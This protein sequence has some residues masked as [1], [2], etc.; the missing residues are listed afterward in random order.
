MK[1]Y[2]QLHRL[3]APLVVA[4]P[5]AI[6]GCGSSSNT[7]EPMV[8]PPPP[9]PAGPTDLEQTQAD[10]AAAAAAAMAA[11]AD[12]AASAAS[13]AMA[14]ANIATHQT[15]GMAADNNMQAQMAAAAAMAAYEAAKAA[16]A[17]AATAADSP[18]AEDARS[19]AL[20]AQ[21]TAEAEAMKAAEAAMK[22][23]EAAMMELKIVGTMK[24]VGESSIDATMGALT[25]TVGEGAAAKTVLTGLR[26]EKTTEGSAVAGRS[27]HPVTAAA[28][29]VATLAVDESKGRAY[30]QMVEA[31]TLKIGKELDTTDDAARLVLFDKYA[32]EN[33]VGVYLKRTLA[34]TEDAADG[35]DVAAGNLFIRTKSD[36]SKI[37]NV[38]AAGNIV[39]PPTDEAGKAS[40]PKAPTLTTIGT[41]IEA[42][43]DA[44]PAAATAPETDAILGITTDTSGTGN[45]DYEDEVKKEAKPKTVSSVKDGDDTRYVVVETTTTNADG[46]VDTEY[47]YVDITALAAAS[48]L[49]AM[50]PIQTRVRANV[51]AAI[52]YKHIHFGA[53][54][55]LSAAKASGAQTIADLGIGFVQSIGTG[56]TGSDM[57]NSGNASYT[58]NWAGMVQ[59]ANAEG[60]GAITLN[61]GAASLAA[62]FA[63]GEIAAT[64]SGLATLEGAITGNTFAGSKATVVSSD[65]Y[66]LQSTAKFTGTFGGG[67]YG[68]G[69]AEAGGIFDFGTT[70]NTG[71]AFRGAF[72]GAKDE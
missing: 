6:A 15:N 41:F 58:G 68:S 60:K 44:T 64:L 10:A 9:P 40:L 22:A 70:D 26:S 14:A 45:L 30:R 2:L 31:R 25:T 51:P 47:R 42:E 16:A 17:S 18:A 71:G 4:V 69:A 24:S 33:P 27:F 48:P 3:M 63:D 57:P 72:G 34:Q 38:D 23:A 21:A 66:G 37:G 62:D 29:D 52:K 46:S 39:A 12:A 65:P 7:P 35:A 5:L 32:G 67:F 55:G 56:M 49:N 36:G 13:A 61:D 8:E 1:K 11:S 19:A 50:T 54:A 43:D 53:W 59:A 28:D 20:L